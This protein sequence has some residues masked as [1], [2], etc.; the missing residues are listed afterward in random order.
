[1]ASEQSSSPTSI[2]PAMCAACGF[3]P[4]TRRR[5]PAARLRVVHHSAMQVLAD[6][7]ERYRGFGYEVGGEQMDATDLACDP[8][9]VAVA[10]SLVEVRR[11]ERH[12]SVAVNRVAK[13]DFPGGIDPPRDINRAARRPAPIR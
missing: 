10:E 4:A 5:K 9:L 6:G 3:A 1:M 12:P 8:T 7:S 13:P 2:C 11:A